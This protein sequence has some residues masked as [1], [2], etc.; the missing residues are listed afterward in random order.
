MFCSPNSNQIEWK[1][2]DINSG[3]EATG[4]A[5][6]LP[7]NT[8][9]FTAGVLASNAIT[10]VTSINLGLNRIYRNRLIIYNIKLNHFNSWFFYANNNNNYIIV[11]NTTK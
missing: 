2:L 8:T 7:A 1:I 5:T 10:P 6:N 11:Y 4:I 3:V 9:L